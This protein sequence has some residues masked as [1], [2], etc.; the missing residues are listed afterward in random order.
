MSIE[1]WEH[2]TAQAWRVLQG[3]LGE[4]LAGEP[5]EQ[6]VIV[7]LPWPEGDLEHAAPYVQ[8]AVLGDGT[9]RSE[10]VSNDYLDPRFR[11]DGMRIDAL[12]GLGWVRGE[13][14][15][16]SGRSRNFWRHDDLPEDADVLAETLVAT[17]RDVYGVPAPCFLEASGFSEAGP[18]EE[19]DLPFG[20]PVVGPVVAPIDVTAVVASD[21]D[22]LRDLVAAA[23]ASVV[24][25]EV[26][27]DADGDIPVPAGNT[28]VYV[29]VA[30]GSPSVRLFAPLLHDVRWTPRVGHVLNEANGRLDYA[31]VAFHSG[32][33]IIEYQMFARP[34]VP[35]LLRHAV[36]GLTRLADGLDAELQGR[37][38]GATL[39]DHQDGIA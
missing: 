9:V 20:L 29:R 8:M 27:F 16:D 1:V 30:E 37:I 18:L 15:G 19:G 34:F 14:D 25:D 21:P 2:E 22:D 12:R 6:S 10:A 39:A 35:E 17:L 7:A 31:R 4:W 11:L 3:L 24:Q 26:E 23:V 32:Q 36:V 5:A 38:G 33:V 28:V 13:D